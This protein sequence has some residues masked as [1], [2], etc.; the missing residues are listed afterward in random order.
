MQTYHEQTAA[1]AAEGY[2]LE[3]GKPGVAI[4]T[5]GPGATN[6]MTGIAD[7][8]F[9]SVPTIFITGQVNTYEYKYDKPVRQQGFQE[10]DVVEIVKPVTKYA[11]LLDN[12]DAIRY[13]LEKA[14]WIAMNG[15]KGPVLIDLPMDISRAEIEPDSLKS[16]IPELPCEKAKCDFGIVNDKIRKA[17]RPLLLLGG[18]CQNCGDALDK[19][20]KETHVP[21]V[22]SLMGRGAADEDVDEYIGMIGSYGNR[23][24]N[25]IIS[26][27]DLLVALGT[28]LD[29]RQTGAR[30]ESFIPDAEI[31]HVDI[32]TN[33][34]E[35]NRLKNRYTLCISVADFVKGFDCHSFSLSTEWIKWIENVKIKYSQKEEVR[36][37]V[38]NKSPYHFFDVFN[39]VS[40]ENAVIST[41]VGQNQMWAAQSVK[42]KKEINFLRAEV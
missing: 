36:R 22:T 6:L 20:I 3:S 8:Y 15:R 38:D 19:F 37:F 5:S 9:G 33:E 12:A 23:C 1:I 39:A 31:I 25:I 11:V 42:L 41:D 27:C 14:Y 35:C 30:V 4:A 16:F 2:A 34:L 29:T 13:E 21:F 24:A 17:K 7:A 18:G 26:Q 40:S 28:R 10:T 32:D